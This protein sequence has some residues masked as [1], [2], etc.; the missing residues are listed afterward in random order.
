MLKAQNK[1]DARIVFFEREAYFVVE[2][3]SVDNKIKCVN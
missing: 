2:R 3:K 1:L